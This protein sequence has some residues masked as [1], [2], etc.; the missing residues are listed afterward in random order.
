[1]MNISQQT[2]TTDHLNR[3]SIDQVASRDEAR[4]LPYRCDD[5]DCFV[6]FSELDGTRR[7]IEPDT[8][9]N[10]LADEGFQR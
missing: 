6:F 9:A 8:D 2:P 7:V 10:S 5:N 1:M 3:P 4:N